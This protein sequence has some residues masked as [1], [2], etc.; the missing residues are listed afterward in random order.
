M[1]AGDVIW[2]NDS[3]FIGLVL[4]GGRV[5]PFKKQSRRGA[6]PHI[7]GRYNEELNKQGVGFHDLRWYVVR[8]AGRAR[9]GEPWGSYTVVGN[10]L[11]CWTDVF[12]VTHKKL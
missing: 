5:A 7:L 12:G 6:L 1:K 10:V 3:A 2:L 8:L 11:D 4:K 9:T